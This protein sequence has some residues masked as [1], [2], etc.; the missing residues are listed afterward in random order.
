MD[1]TRL[2]QVE[3]HSR[4]ACHVRVTD[5]RHG[6]CIIARRIVSAAR[7][8]GRCQN[9][10]RQWSTGLSNHCC[11]HILH[12]PGH[13]TCSALTTIEEC[14]SL[15]TLC[16]IDSRHT[17]HLTQRT[18]PGLVRLHSD[19]NLSQSAK[20]PFTIAIK[21]SAKKLSV[22]QSVEH[23]ANNGQ[24]IDQTQPPSEHSHHCSLPCV[25]WQFGAFPNI[26][27]D[28]RLKLTPSPYGRVRR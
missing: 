17:A 11:L 9:L 13:G 19:A 8:I 25:C 23:C 14:C 10:P 15:R 3:L 4:D 28:R 7:S 1:Q 5:G 26:E 18:A 12:D 27:I 21:N 24:D 6:W 22:T 20:K 2:P 16:N